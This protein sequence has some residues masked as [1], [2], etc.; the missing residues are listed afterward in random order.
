MERLGQE[1]GWDTV[2]VPHPLREAI[3][4]LDAIAANTRVL[5][6]AAGPAGLMAVVKADAYGHGLVP[7]ARAAVAGGATWL[8]VAL[9]E[10]ALFLRAAGFEV[11][12]LAWLGGPGES[13]QQAIEQDIDVSVN[14]AWALDDVSAAARASGRVARIHLKVDTGLGRAGSARADWEELV[15][16]ARKAEIDDVVRV[17]GVWSHFAYADAPGHPTI[18]SQLAA[19]TDAIHI[20]ERHGLRPEVRHLANSAATITRPDTLFDLARPGLAVY[21][22]SPVP[23]VSTAGELGL[24][25]AMSLQARLALVK[26]V[27]AGHGVSYGHRYV[28]TRTTTLGLV[29]MGYADGIPRNA[30]NIGP[31]L[32]A[33]E[34]RTIAGTVCMDQ[35]MLDLEEAGAR[36]G[37]PVHIFGPGSIGEPTAQDW[38][39]ALQTI[40]YEIVSRVGPRVRRRYMG[41]DQ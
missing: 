8:G 12:V 23:D 6:D 24:Q 38:A 7:S 20:A 3:I 11:P 9:L 26:V 30:S 33:G 40:S 19:F 1:P 17:V 5:A 28:T 27:P 14:A 37:D 16:Y 22:L 13:W 36:E 18:D 29:P 32:A 34:R 39:D 4:D 21:G 10:E 35:F 25:P 31:V 2:E 41:G 15:D